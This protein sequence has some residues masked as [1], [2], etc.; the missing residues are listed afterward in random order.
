DE[1]RALARAEHRAADA[2]GEAQARGAH[3][4]ADH[5]ADDRDGDDRGDRD[6]RAGD[7]RREQRV[8]VVARREVVGDRLGEA[9][10]GE[11]GAR[12][13]RQRERLAH[14]ADP[15]AAQDGGGQDAGRGEID[16]ARR[17]LRRDVRHEPPD[18]K[19]ARSVTIAR[20]PLIGGSVQGR[21]DA[22]VVGAGHNGLVAAAYLAR[23][24][25]RTV[26]L[27]RRERIGGACAT[28]PLWPG[29]RVSRAAYVAGLLRP[30]VVAEL[31]LA[32]RGLRL[33]RRDPS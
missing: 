2:V 32:A 4:A 3:R 21:Y 11:D 23:A 5:E 14:E 26:V 17:N 31:G 24:G 10:H 28:E 30:A 33:L 22:I 9:A 20:R 8:E 18:P 13:R 16:D 7:R 19:R 6:A 1:E 12:E 15:H 25:L 27:E 29:Y